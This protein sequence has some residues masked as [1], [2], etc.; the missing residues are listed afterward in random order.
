MQI[1]AVHNGKRSVAMLSEMIKHNTHLT[2]YY[3]YGPL[4]FSKRPLRW[5]VTV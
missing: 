5:F 4:R 2:L 3:G 1:A